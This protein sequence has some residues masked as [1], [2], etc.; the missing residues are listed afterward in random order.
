MAVDA[1][2]VAGMEYSYSYL[3]SY[4][5]EYFFSVLSCTLFLGKFM[6][7]CT[8]SYLSTVTK[9]PVLMSTL[10]VL[11][12]T[13]FFNFNQIGKKVNCFSGPPSSV[14][15]APHLSLSDLKKSGLICFG[16][17]K[18]INKKPACL[19]CFS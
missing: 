3:Y 14:S 9:N 13:F 11:L 8:R 7:T 4:L 16:E 10:R 19:I 2:L 17:I 6:I 12:G 1:V 5:L 15:N 18:N